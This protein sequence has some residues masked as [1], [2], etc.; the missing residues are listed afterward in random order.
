MRWSVWPSWMGGEARLHGG[1]GSD[2]SGR[3][4]CPLWSVEQG[5]LFLTVLCVPGWQ[6]SLSSAAGRLCVPSHSSVSMGPRGSWLMI[7]V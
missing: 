3:S 5:V 1:S 2:L 7:P 4:G 6:G